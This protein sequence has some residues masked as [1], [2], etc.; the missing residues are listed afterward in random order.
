MYNYKEHKPTVFTEE[1]QVRFLKIRDKMN[2]L[3]K[4]SGVCTMDE[5]T[6][7][8]GGSSWDQMACV[9]RL[10]EL[11]EFVEVIQLEKPIAQHRIFKNG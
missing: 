11:N 10:V 7:G 2:A 6:R 4:L 8:S 1:G 9:D 3:I 5:A